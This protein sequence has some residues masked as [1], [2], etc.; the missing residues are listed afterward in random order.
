M[1][2]SLILVFIGLSI[3]LL[4]A[5]NFPTGTNAVHK[6][7]SIIVSW[8]VSAVV[9][10]GYINIADTALTYTEAGIT[11]NKAWSGSVEDA[12][13]RAEGK[14]ISLGDGG[15][16]ILEFENPI[17]DGPGAD[18]VVFENAIFSPPNQTTLAFLEL[19][20]VEVSSNGVDF[21][22]FP[23]VSE[24][25]YE[26]QI[27]SFQAVD[28]KYFKNFA[29]IY[30]VFYG[31]PFD[32]AEISDEN[33]DKNNITH[34]KIVDVVG[35][36]NPEFASYDSHGNIVNDAWPTAFAT[37]GFDLDAVGVINSTSGI[38]EYANYNFQ[39][40]PNPANDFISIKFE[41]KIEEFFLFDSQSKVL[42][43]EYS[44]KP[45]SQINLSEL[46][47]GL[48]FVKIFDGERFF[49]QKLVKID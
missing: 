13:G 27:S 10:R 1:K 47:Q 7:S 45:N 23:A 48:Y 30:P 6:D 41:S 31:V 34:V 37:C 14:T 9:E 2:I 33:I 22:R 11:S 44:I 39:I 32:L 8:A 42:I 26:T 40:F 38:D 5:Q 35:Y 29:G 16:I 19:A 12:L 17:F 20:F 3:N 25:Q 36:I 24:Y 46:K 28:R 18:F 21:V 4:F 15:N 43:H 49:N